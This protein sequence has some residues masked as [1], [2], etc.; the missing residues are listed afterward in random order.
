MFLAPISGWRDGVKQSIVQLLKMKTILNL[1]AVG[2]NVETIDSI[3]NRCH[4]RDVTH[5]SLKCR[6]K[7]SVVSLAATMLAVRL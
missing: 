5:R 2:L 1:I 3:K 7:L 6:L 4:I